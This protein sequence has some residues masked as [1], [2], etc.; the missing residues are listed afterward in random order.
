MVNK[1]NESVDLWKKVSPKEFEFSRQ[2]KE[3]GAR[4]ESMKVGE[5]FVAIAFGEEIV[6]WKNFEQFKSHSI[7]HGSFDYRHPFVVTNVPGR[8]MLVINIESESEET[9]EVP[10]NSK[11]LIN[12]HSHSIN[13]FEITDNNEGT[14]V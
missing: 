2:I 14:E 4:I 13:H 8:R 3:G 1:I 12:V 7:P 11:P 6:I 5:N 10:I 9:V